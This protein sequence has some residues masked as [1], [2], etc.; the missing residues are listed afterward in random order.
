MD[1]NM[2]YIIYMDLYIM[3]VWL[4]ANKCHMIIHLVT[5]ESHYVMAKRQN[6]A[7]KVGYHYTCMICCMC[8]GGGGGRGG[9][10]ELCTNFILICWSVF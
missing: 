7:P 1:I 4:G 3:T 5:H 10:F 6:M 8:G 9:A 2:K